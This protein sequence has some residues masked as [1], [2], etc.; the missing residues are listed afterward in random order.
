MAKVKAIVLRDNIDILLGTDH[1]LTRSLLVGR[2]HDPTLCKV[3]AITRAQSKTQER[4]QVD[5]IAADARDGAVSKQVKLAAPTSSPPAGQGKGKTPKQNL[6]L[7][8]AGQLE[9]AIPDLTQST[10]P[11]IEEGAPMVPIKKTNGSLQ[12]CIDYRKLNRSQ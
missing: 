7:M 4:E 8:M 5:N 9:G 6:P 1:P 12:L 11:Q 3:R 10:S 2:K